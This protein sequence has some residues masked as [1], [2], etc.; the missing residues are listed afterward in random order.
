MVALSGLPSRADTP[1]P[2]P[3]P[4]SSASST[5]SPSPEPTPDPTPEPLPPTPPPAAIDVAPPTAAPAAIDPAYLG[6][7]RPGDWVQITGTG[8]CLNLRWEPLIPTTQPDGT[9][10]DNVINC[11]PDG[12]IGRLD[13]SGWG[14]TTI[15]VLESGRWWWHILGQGWAAEE[16]L[17]FHHQGGIPW[18]E[19]L[20]LATAGLIAYIGTDNGLWLMNADGRNS[21]PVLSGDPNQWV[22]T[23]KWSPAGDRLAFSIG[24]PDGTALTRMIDLNGNVLS[25]KPGLWEPRWSPSGR[26]ISGIRTSPAAIGD[27]RPLRWCS[28][29]KLV[30]NGPLGPPPTH[31]LLLRGVPMAITSP[32][33]AHPVIS[34]SPMARWLSKKGET[35]TETA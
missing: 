13:A 20:D 27:T 17:T 10:Y 35:V 29:P 18:P 21:R 26:H 28:T 1:T 6:S 12:F 30:R 32:S 15:P 23:V 2:T 34:A 5:P 22:Q 3:E 11:L 9:T 16:W 14:R 19:R 25:E 4:S 8:S 33:F 24:R 7:L 31:M